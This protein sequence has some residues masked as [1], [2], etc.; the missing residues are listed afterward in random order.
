MI[1]KKWAEDKGLKDAVRSLADKP[2]RWLK[3]ITK[4]YEPACA[5]SAGIAKLSW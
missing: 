1:L 3:D 4:T 2:V 5:A